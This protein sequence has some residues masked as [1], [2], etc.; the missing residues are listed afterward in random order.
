MQSKLIHEADGQ[1]TYA[2]VLASGD[3][4]MASL[5]SFAQAEQLSA[6]GFTAIG[7]FERAELAYFD[8]E[9]KQYRAIPV[10]AQV[11][12][13]SFTGDVVLGPDGEPAVHAHAVLGLHNGSA[14]AGHLQRGI[15]RP[16]LEIIL[17]ESPSYLR[18]RLDPESGIPLIDPGKA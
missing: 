11:E 7:A 5:K 12:V 14:L 8:W 13:A 9:T 6:A 16:T 3:E 17:T 10:D 2:I 4:A 1:K 15:V 18:K